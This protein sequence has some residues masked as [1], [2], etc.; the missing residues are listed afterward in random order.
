[1]KLT[2]KFLALFIPI[3]FLG[4]GTTE[5]SCSGVVIPDG[6]GQRWGLDG[7]SEPALEETEK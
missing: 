2:I 3:L 6:V 7:W 4:C 1:M 5:T